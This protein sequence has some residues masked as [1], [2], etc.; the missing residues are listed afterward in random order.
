MVP[1][2]GNLI[3][4]RGWHAGQPWSKQQNPSKRARMLAN[5]PNRNGQHSSGTRNQEPVAPV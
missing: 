2:K 3:L 4:A 1:L 5:I